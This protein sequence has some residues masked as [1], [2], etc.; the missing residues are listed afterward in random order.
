VSRGL[1]ALLFLLLSVVA[2]GSAFAVNLLI[3]R[4]AAVPEAGSN[5]PSVASRS[6]AARAGRTTGALS[7]EQYLDGIMGRNLFD[8]AI[9]D[10][11]AARRPSAG[12]GDAMARTELHVRLLGTMVADPESFSSALIVEEDSADLPR[13][14]SIGDELHEREVVSIEHDRVGLKKAD[15]SIEYVTMDGGPVRSI[16]SDTTEPGGE[17]A[18][19]VREVAEGKYEVDRATFDKYI[20]DLE[21]ISKMGRALLH[22]GP[23]G[24]FDGYRLSAI[25]RGTIADMLGIKNGDIIQSVNGESLNSVQS[26]M[27]AYN[28]MKTQSNFCF[29]ISRRGSPT[30]LCYDVR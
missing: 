15:G 22:R 13:A 3:G 12:G 27:G 26:A 21:G 7:V 24:E 9:I 11:W 20:N 2:G 8:V 25:R 5:R 23:D 4:L 30:Q 18:E 1:P 28:T 19:G 17:E 29:E 14:Y 16:A 6:D 10:A